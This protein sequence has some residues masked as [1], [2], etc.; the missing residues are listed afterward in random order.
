VTEKR[1]LRERA[2]NLGGHP[3]ATLPSL[4]LL[5]EVL[6]ALGVGDAENTVGPL[7]ELHHLRSKVKGHA[8]GAEALSIKQDVLKN[9][10]GFK[11]HFRKLC[12]RADEAFT[13]ITAALK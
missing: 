2:I 5:E 7:R 4:S 9:H 6:I 3:D 10:G 11:A 1:W 8:S 13:V 12:E